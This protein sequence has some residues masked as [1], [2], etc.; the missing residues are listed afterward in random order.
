M[1]DYVGIL[2]VT[3]VFGP[4]VILWWAAAMVAIYEIL[5]SALN[6]QCH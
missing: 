3:V 2:V 6:G 5:K 1:C 4:L